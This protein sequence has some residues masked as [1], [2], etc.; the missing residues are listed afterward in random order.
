M[1]VAIIQ[2]NKHFNNWVDSYGA[3][4]DGVLANSYYTR[5]CTS[6]SSNLLTATAPSDDEYYVVWY[7]LNS[8][9]TCVS[10]I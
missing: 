6:P 3:D 4:N 7:T 5:A 8:A 9:S 1:S 2:G 10:H